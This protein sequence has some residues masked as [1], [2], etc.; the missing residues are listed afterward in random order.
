MLGTADRIDEAM[1]A[2][3]VTVPATVES[4]P[5]ADMDIESEEPVDEAA[6][7]DEDDE[8]LPVAVVLPTALIGEAEAEAT[9]GLLEDDDDMASF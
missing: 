3:S 9:P 1:V 5:D 6:I 8:E 7:I 2:V 4:T